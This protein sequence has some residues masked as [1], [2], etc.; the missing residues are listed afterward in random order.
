MLTNRL[1]LYQRLQADLYSKKYWE[2]GGSGQVGKIAAEKKSLVK[3]G[4]VV[5]PAGLLAGLCHPRSCIP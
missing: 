3:K 5:Q 2:L 4:S 1:N